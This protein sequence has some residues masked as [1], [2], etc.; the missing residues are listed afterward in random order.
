MTEK[1]QKKVDE[2]NKKLEEGKVA[3]IAQADADAK[4]VIA[5][6]ALKEAKDAKKKADDARKALEKDTNKTTKSKTSQMK[7]LTKTKQTK[8]DKEQ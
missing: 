8:D 6:K 5:R 1:L 3:E 4:E 7:D 2:A